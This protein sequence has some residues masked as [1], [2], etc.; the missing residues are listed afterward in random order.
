MLEMFAAVLRNW[1]PVLVKHLWSGELP[2]ESAS[3]KDFP[4]AWLAHW[5]TRRYRFKSPPFVFSES[6]EPLKA[7]NP[8]F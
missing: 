7:K 8:E 1:G 5:N 2:C 4:S 3:L 6:G